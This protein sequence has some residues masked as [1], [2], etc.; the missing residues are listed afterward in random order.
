MQHKKSAH[1]KRKLL[2]S[3]DRRCT[4]S[5]PPNGCFERR[6]RAERRLPIVEEGVVSEKEWFKRMA[7]FKTKSRAEQLAELKV[8]LG[9]VHGHN[10]ST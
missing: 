9:L 4:E 3:M 8:R 6:K 1:N 2:E 5:N 10:E 7:L